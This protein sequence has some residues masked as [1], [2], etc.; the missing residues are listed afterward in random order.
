MSPNSSWWK[1]AESPWVR[2]SYCALH[3]LRIWLKVPRNGVSWC[4]ELGGRVD[5]GLLFKQEEGDASVCP[6]QA[7]ER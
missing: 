5:G 7:L 2:W 6:S 3:Q 1:S 4:K